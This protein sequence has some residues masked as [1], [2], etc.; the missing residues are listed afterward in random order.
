LIQQHIGGDDQQAVLGE[1]PDYLLA[2][3]LLLPL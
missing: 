1:E 2:Q 3:A